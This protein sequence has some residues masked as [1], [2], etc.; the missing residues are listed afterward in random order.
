MSWA[1][2]IANICRRWLQREQADRELDA[3]VQS[4]FDIVAERL[5]AT[6]LSREEAMR[7]ARL[8]W[9][10][11]EQVKEKVRQARMGFTIETTARDIRYAW[12]TLRKSPGFTV[13]SV[14]TLGL[15]IGA[16]SAIFTLIN[17]VMLRALPVQ[18]PEQLVLL[19][20]PS[21]SGVAME[22]TEHGVRRNLSYQE[23]QQLRSHNTVFS[24]LLATQNDVSDVDVLP[25]GG[26]ESQIFKAH[27]QLVS[28]EFFQVLGIH[29]I[30][31]RFFTPEEDKAPGADPVAVISY[32]Y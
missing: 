30:M 19:T 22:T 6:G 32:S 26:S 29:P 2:T 18:H 8:Q 14:L 17:A 13:V 31:G 7:S 20:D 1:T 3:E 21:E 5:M 15:G 27:V 23:F 24:G 10:G 4:Y 11:P 16:N 12:R 28:G 25:E 9:E